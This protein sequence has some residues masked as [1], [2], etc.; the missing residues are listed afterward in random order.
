MLVALFLTLSSL[1]AFALTVAL[2]EFGAP[3]WAFVVLLSWLAT[4]GAPASAG[5]LAVVWW[6]PGGSFT[7][8]VALAGVAAL[9]AQ[10]AGVSIVA[11]WLRR[12]RE[13]THRDRPT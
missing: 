6:W 9:L 1:G 3:A 11:R 12:R 2:G 4:I 13:K 10:T 5:V 8:F 7:T